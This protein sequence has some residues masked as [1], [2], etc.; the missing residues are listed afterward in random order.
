[1]KKVYAIVCLT[2][3]M[4][5]TMYA[6]DTAKPAPTDTERRQ[7]VTLVRK[8]ATAEFSYR[9][10]SGGK[11]GTVADLINAG[12]VKVDNADEPLSGFKLRV[13]V[14]ADGSKFQLSLIHGATLWGLFSD[15]NAL[16]YI[17]EGMR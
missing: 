7:A 12:L 6:A 15:E 14:S 16:I 8:V 5:G 3:L 10:Q 1:M 17:G 4:L 2:L 11:Y 13:V 9:T